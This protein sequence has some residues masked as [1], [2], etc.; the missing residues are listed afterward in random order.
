MALRDSI[1]AAIDLPRKE[2]HVP[3]WGVVIWAVTL[4]VAQRADLEAAMAGKPRADQ[5]VGW[6]IA[7]TRDNDGNPVFLPDDAVWL[8]EKN[9]AAV[10]RVFEA[11]ARLNALT[12]ADVEEIEKN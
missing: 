5:V 11:V 10:L 7:G 6:V 9:A 1:L 8:R 4:S 2:I 3:E 12:D